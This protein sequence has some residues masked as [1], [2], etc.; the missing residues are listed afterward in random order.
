MRRFYFYLFGL[1]LA[2]LSINTLAAEKM[3]QTKAQLKTV[4]VYLNA[5][6]LTHQVRL[7][8]PE[9]YQLLSLKTS[10]HKYRKKPYK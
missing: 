5:A 1:L 7:D 8:V 9:G 10:R 2:F 4:T 3:I 6:E